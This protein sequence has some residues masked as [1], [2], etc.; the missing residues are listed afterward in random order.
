MNRTRRRFA[1]CAAT[2][3]LALQDA[4]ARGIPREDVIWPRG[5]ALLERNPQLAIILPWSFDSHPARD[6]IATL[7]AHRLNP[8]GWPQPLP[9]R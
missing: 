6:E 3:P 4:A 8:T 5:V 7:I 2:Q 9:T 1:I